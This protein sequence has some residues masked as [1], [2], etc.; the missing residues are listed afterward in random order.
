[1]FTSF[2]NRST[3]SAFSAF[4]ASRQCGAIARAEPERSDG[5]DVEHRLE[6]LV[7]HLVGDS[8]PRVAGVV[9]EDV[10]LAELV[11]GLLHKFVRNARIGQVAGEDSRLAVDLRRCLL[12][13]VAV[14][15]VDEDS[16]ALAYE[17]LRRR[18][19]DAASRAGDDRVLSVEKSHCFQFLL[20]KFLLCGIGGRNLL[21]RLK[22]GA[23]G[24]RDAE[25][26]PSGAPLDRHKG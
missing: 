3:P 6:L 21:D 19:A 23:I 17:E 18:A 24:H 14:D 25:A 13:D 8:V 5:V 26:A 10:D 7:G 12:G 11:D 4:A 22:I 15:V 16:R 9:H 20:V 2:R 1:M